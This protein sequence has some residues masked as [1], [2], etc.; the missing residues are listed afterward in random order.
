MMLRYLLY[1]FFFLLPWQTRWLIQTGQLNGG[2]W[3]YG[4]ISLYGLDLLLI[5][6]LIIFLYF[7]KSSLASKSHIPF[8]LKLYLLLSLLYLVITIPFS[9]SPTLSLFHGGLLLVSVFV[10]YLCLNSDLRFYNAT[11]AFISGAT[12]S[13]G[14][15]IWQFITQTT[16][17][18]KWLGLANHS[19]EVLGTSV[20]EAVAPD[21][22]IERWLRAYGSFDHP[23]IFGGYMA[24]ALILAVWIWLTRDASRK[25]FEN[26][27]L[28]LSIITLTTAVFFSF[29][30]TAWLVSSLG[31]ITL[32]LFF[33]LHY[34][35]QR[36]E[37]IGVWAIIIVISS[38]IMSQYYYLLIPRFKAD[39]RLETISL[40]ERTA[41]LETSWELIQQKPILG[42][43]LGTYT[44]AVAKNNTPNQPAWFYQPVHNIFLLIVVETGIL[45][46]L[47][48]L[49]ILRNLGIYFFKKTPRAQTGL[50]LALCLGLFLIALFDHWL[51]S[52]HAGLLVGA[53]IFSLLSLLRREALLTE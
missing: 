35:Q 34:K 40:T 25:K 10:I 5:A 16:V 37:L 42:Q 2:Y 24:L 33:F 30:R 36:R 38:L 6:S 32:S 21:G 14:L 4:T 43:G 31:L 50:G 7:K 44:L 1:A 45:G 46:L 8:T 51:W 28:M 11:R 17:T 13:A 22:I 26:Y 48:C 12:L 19:A 39:S 27:G 15:G 29:S 52:L 47:L 20:V 49:L 53:T 18:S 3:E 9:L 41:S 23:N